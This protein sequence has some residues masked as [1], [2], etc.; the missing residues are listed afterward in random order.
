MAVTLEWYCKAGGVI[1]F[2]FPDPTLHVPP[3]VET[4][5]SIA[6]TQSREVEAMSNASS[7][8]KGEHH[9]QPWAMQ[10]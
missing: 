5:W 6:L 1:L 3:S 7:S 2:D 10:H 4:L 8:R 9:V